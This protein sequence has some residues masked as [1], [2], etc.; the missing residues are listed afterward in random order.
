MH[1]VT[2][3]ESV[4]SVHGRTTAP[5]MLRAG[6]WRRGEVFEVDYN[7]Q[8]APREER[9]VTQSIDGCDYNSRHAPRPTDGTPFSRAGAERARCCEEEE[10]EAAM[11]LNKNHSEGG[12]VIVNNSE[13]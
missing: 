3:A 10:E 8:H 5:G 6:K 12:G 11:A 13:K 2:D 7:S 1:G 9:E 4:N